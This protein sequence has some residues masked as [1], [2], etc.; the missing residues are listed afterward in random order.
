MSWGENL[1]LSKLTTN[2]SGVILLALGLVIAYFSTKA[3]M[4]HA[5]PRIFTPVGLIV[6]LIGGILII[7]WEG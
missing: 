1:T 4:G 5:T 7:A 2:L 3:D 6:A